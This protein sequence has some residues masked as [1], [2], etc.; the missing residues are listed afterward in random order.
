MN[1]K[2]KKQLKEKIIEL[3]TKSEQDI[4]DMEKNTQPVVPE[5]SLGRIS[6]MDAINNKSVMEAALRNKRKK[7]SKLKTALSHIGNDN[8]GLCSSCKNEIQIKRLLF[9]PESDQ[10][11]RCASR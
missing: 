7:L 10:C 3:I 2:S 1:K 4:L 11:V 9:M 5:N 8:F 6:R